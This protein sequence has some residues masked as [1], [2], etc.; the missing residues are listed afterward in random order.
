MTA[1]LVAARRIGAAADARHDGR[2]GRQRRAG[3]RRR[4]H[5][6]A[7]I[8]REGSAQ[9]RAGIVVHRLSP[10]GHVGCGDDEDGRG[11]ELPRGAVW[12]K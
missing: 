5:V 1:P 8:G 7:G 4:R 3:H 12:Q 2:V 9:L 10:G 11:D 6:A